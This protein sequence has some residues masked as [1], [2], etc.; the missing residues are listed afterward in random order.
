MN[1]TNLIA[2]IGKQTVV[3]CHTELEARE[4]IRSFDEIRG[5]KS[6]NIC[7]YH[8]EFTCYKLN[9]NNTWD[10]CDVRFYKLRGFDI[11]NFKDIM[12]NE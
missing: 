4:L 10:C 5:S 8:D 11:L 12:E 2:L 9:K 3:R 7:W 6:P 1:D